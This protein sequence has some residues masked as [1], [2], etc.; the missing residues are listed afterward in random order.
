[1]EYSTALLCGIDG[2]DG[3]GKAVVAELADNV[4][5]VKKCLKAISPKSEI[6]IAEKIYAAETLQVIADYAEGG[7]SD[8]ARKYRT[9]IV[10]MLA[11]KTMKANGKTFS[12]L[13]IGQRVLM[14]ETLIGAVNGCE[15]VF[16][17]Y[18][19]DW[20]EEGVSDAHG[21]LATVYL[22]LA[23]EYLKRNDFSAAERQC[24]SALEHIKQRRKEPDKLIEAMALNLKGLSRE[25][26]GIPDAFEYFDSAVD[27]LEAMTEKHPN[28]LLT[29]DCS[30]SILFNRAHSSFA[31]DKYGEERRRNDLTRVCELATK[32]FELTG[33]RY[34]KQL[35][36]SAQSIK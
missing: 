12:A 15:E 8:S 10:K 16:K 17:L 34:Y 22:C 6:D 19:K 29:D 9:E 24:D 7:S 4:K 13:S 36:L 21:E 23:Y 33:I 14:I 2:A 31:P 28:M 25:A 30:A 18:H 26:C 1:M 35:M 32:L 5:F 11:K 27:A 20:S 3:D